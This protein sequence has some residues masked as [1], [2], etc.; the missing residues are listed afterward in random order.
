[1][2][3]D[4][5]IRNTDLNSETFVLALSSKDFDKNYLKQ[6]S[7]EDIAYQYM[8]DSGPFATLSTNAALESKTLGQTVIVA[9]H[10][11]DVLP[12]SEPASS[13]GLRGSLP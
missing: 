1:V 7:C 2:T 8:T 12:V 4:V 6:T 11:D 3:E 10:I 9:A 5:E 13:P